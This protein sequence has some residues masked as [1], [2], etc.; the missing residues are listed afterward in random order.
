VSVIN[1][2][3]RRFADGWGMV[4]VSRDTQIGPLSSNAARSVTLPLWLAQD[5]DR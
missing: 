2:I 3:E 4:T 1:V 5:H